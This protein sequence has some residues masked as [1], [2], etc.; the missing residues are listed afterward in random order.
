MTEIFEQI[1][2]AEIHRAARVCFAEPY[3]NVPKAVDERLWHA[4]RMYLSYRRP[5]FETYEPPIWF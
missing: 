4:E 2:L 3:V 5:G 1:W